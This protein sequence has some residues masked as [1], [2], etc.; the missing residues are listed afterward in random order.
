MNI[1]EVKD[2]RK[3]FGDNEVLK[4]ISLSLKKGEVLSIIGSSGGGKTTLL[5]C[6]NFLEIANSGLITV[7]DKTDYFTADLGKCCCHSLHGGLTLR[8][9]LVYKL[10]HNIGHMYRLTGGQV[11][12]FIAVKAQLAGDGVAVLFQLI[13]NCG[14]LGDPALQYTAVSVGD[15]AYLQVSLPLG[16][17]R[18]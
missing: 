16:N 18:M 12:V 14:S 10:A 15:I 3:R 9:V 11:Y 17:K 4:G 5:R 2:L 8:P 1:L 7:G 6:L 13:G